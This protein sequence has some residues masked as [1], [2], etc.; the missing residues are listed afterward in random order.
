MD[1]KKLNN[2]LPIDH[3]NLQWPELSITQSSFKEICSIN[4]S[5]NKE[6]ELN[7]LFKKEYNVSLPAPGKM[8]N[9][10][11]GSVFWVSPA[12]WFVTSNEC[13]PYFDQ[14]LA[15]KFNTVSTV[16][17]QTDAWISIKIEGKAS[18]DVLERLVKIDLNDHNFPTGSATR[19]G[20][21]HMTI[22]LQKP[23]QEECFLIFGARSYAQ[24]LVHTIT[25]A[26]ENVLVNNN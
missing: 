5:L 6:S 17:L 24:S 15:K 1:K 21:S 12:Q 9:Y 23:Y 18:L 26:A 3:L 20:C 10:S 8:I 19:T 2:A 7:E 22:F 25:Q 4:A 11:T 13:N 14:Q 16:T